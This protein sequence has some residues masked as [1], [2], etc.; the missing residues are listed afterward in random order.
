MIAY[1]MDWEIPLSGLLSVPAIGLDY[2]GTFFHEIGHTLIYWMFGYP[3][4]PSFDFQH[5]GGMTY[6]LERPEYGAVAVYILIAVA[7]FGLFVKRHFL[8]LGILGGFT[9]VHLAIAFNQGHEALMLFMG[10]GTEI[11]IG[12]FCILRG[13]IGHNEYGSAERWLNMVFGMFIVLK[14]A[15]MCYGLMFDD[16]TRIVY[17]EQKGG[18]GLGDFSRIAD[19]AGTKVEAVAAFAMLYTAVLVGIA[20]F[21]GIRERRYL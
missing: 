1:R 20:V 16:I 13:I 11:L 15:V 19:I 14:N 21:I 10:H 7:A 6:G 9:V 4:M 12:S 2:M 18:H 8:L 17:E 5:G 3:A